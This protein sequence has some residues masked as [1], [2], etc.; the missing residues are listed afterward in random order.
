MSKTNKE[1]VKQADKP[2][3]PEVVA[4]IYWPKDE[5]KGKV[6][7]VSGVILEPRR[8]EIDGETKNF[9][10]RDFYNDSYKTWLKRGYLQLS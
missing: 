3:F 2:S 1:E 9:A 4:T 7:P 8:L 10:A 5:G 6:D